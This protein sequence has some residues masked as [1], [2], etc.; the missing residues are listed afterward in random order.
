MSRN[1]EKGSLNREA[2]CCSHV[3]GYCTNHRATLSMERKSR[4]FS[5]CLFR[6][7][8]RGECRFRKAEV[9]GPL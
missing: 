3:L 4:F 7:K 1:V 6:S 9:A 8:E 2:E 5:S